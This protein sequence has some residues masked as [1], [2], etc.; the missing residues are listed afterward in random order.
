MTDSGMY[1]RANRLSD[2]PAQSTRARYRV[3]SPVISTP[4]DLNI[5]SGA[6]EVAFRLDAALLR[7]SDEIALKNLTG[8]ALYR[9]SVR[10]ARREDCIEIHD[11]FDLVVARIERT[12]VSPLRDRFVLKLADLPELTIEG[13]VAGHEFTIADRSGLVAVASRKWFRS[14]G[15][16]GLEVAPG[17]QDGL[18]LTAVL[19][20]DCMIRG[21]E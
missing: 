16:Y 15:S 18:L 12:L 9:A 3:F 13:N 19:T 10:M 7:M 21:L 6:G 1:G 8:D 20:M 2:G 17:S 5:L 4:D 14:R 11:A